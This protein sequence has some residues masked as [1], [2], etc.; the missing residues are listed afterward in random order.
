[1]SFGTPTTHG[2]TITRT[3]TVQST[4]VQ[5]CCLPGGTDRCDYPA[6]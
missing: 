2:S 3:V 5:K 6:C 4:I 1:L